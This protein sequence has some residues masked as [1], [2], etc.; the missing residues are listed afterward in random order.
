MLAT[1]DKTK[2]VTDT[3]RQS[4]SESMDGYWYPMDP[5]TPLVRIQVA[6]SGYC[7]ERRR[8]GNTPWMPIV[9]AE[10]PEFDANAF[11]TWRS[12]WPMVA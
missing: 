7:I 4:F 12:R 9:T 3:L 1:L 2:Q 8:N 10:L 5:G 6:S 11:Q